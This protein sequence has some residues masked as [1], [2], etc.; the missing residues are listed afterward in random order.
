M[1]LGPPLESPL[2]R[3]YHPGLT[4]L[5]LYTR[6]AIYP[7]IYEFLKVFETALAN[8]VQRA[9][10]WA[11]KAFFE[12]PDSPGLFPLSH[13]LGDVSSRISLSLSFR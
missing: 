6:C 7:P 2:L 10:G 4:P 9:L 1:H 11:N 8:L 3:E 13:A 12:G 5:A